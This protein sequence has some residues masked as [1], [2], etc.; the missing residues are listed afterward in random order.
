MARIIYDPALPAAARAAVEPLM[1][2]YA[3]LLPGWAEEVHVGY[4]HDGGDSAAKVLVRQEYRTCRIVVCEG[5][6]TDTPEAQDGQVL[7][8]ILH[9]PLMPMKSLVWQILEALNAEEDHPAIYRWA[10]SLAE[11][12]NEGAVQDLTNALPRWVERERTSNKAAA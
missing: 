12:A 3:P 10:T 2:R 8:E 11:T 6:L 9:V 7:H 5:F 4:L 1:D